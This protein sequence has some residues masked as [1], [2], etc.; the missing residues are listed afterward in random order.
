[1]DPM[2]MQEQEQG[3]GAD[4]VIIE[5]LTELVQQGRSKRA[6][7]VMAPPVEEVAPP[8]GDDTEMAEL[9]QMLGDGSGPPEETEAPAEEAPGAEL[10]EGECPKCGKSPCAC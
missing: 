7:A 9:E 6:E 3:P 10:A 4:E 5:L 2:Q 1:M 8:M